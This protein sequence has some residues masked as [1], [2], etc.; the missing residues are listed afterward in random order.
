MQRE[1][2][3]N[4]VIPKPMPEDV[5]LSLTR[6]F[7]DPRETVD[8]YWFTDTIREYFERILELVAQ[9]RGQ[10]FWIEAEY[11]AGKTHF[12]ATL[13][14]LLAHTDDDTLWDLAKDDAV[15]TYRR[16]LASQRLFPVVLSLKGQSGVDEWSGRT[17]L[18][19]LEREGFGEALK[20]VG[21]HGQIQV[22]STD[23]LLAWFE[24]REAG[25]RAAIEWY[26]QA[27][28]DFTPQGY[29]AGHGRRALADVIRRYCDANDIQP[30][31]SASVKER[32]VH[33]FN[34]LTSPGLASRGVE[35][36][37]A[38]LVVID[39][40]EF[41]D[42]LHPSGTPEAAHDEEVLETLSFIMAKDLGLP[43][44]TLVGSQ[45][46]VPAKLRGGQEG[47]RFINT[48]LLKGA[49]EREY[50][51]IV[52]HRI[53]EL[54]P[55]RTPEINQY[56]DYYVSQFEFAKE[57]DRHTFFNIFPF[58]PHCFE[59]VRKVTAR[60]LPTARSGIYI[61]NQTLN[62][63]EAL[64]RDTLLIVSDLLNSQHLQEALS[65]TV[66]KE[67][68]QAYR[69]ALEALPSL[70]LDD[71]DGPLAEKILKTLFLWYLAYLE[72]PQLMSL[73]DLVEATLTSSDFLRNEDLV[74]LVLDR[75][76]VLPQIDFKDSSAS[77][78][79]A[80]VGVEPFFVKFDRFKRQITDRHEMQRAWQES[81]FFSPMETGGEQSLFGQFERDTLK[82]F[83]ISHHRIEY[84]GELVVATRWRAEYGQ[85][86]QAKDK[87]FRVVILTQIE[88]V[89]PLDLQDPR[90]AV[91][92]PG[93]LTPDVYEAA[94]DHLAAQAMA[95]DYRNRVGKEAEEVRQELRMH[96]R[97]QVIRNLLATHQRIYRAGRVVT[98]HDL[99]IKAADVFS[100]PSNDRR[101]EYVVDKLLISAYPN[102]PVQYG[103]LRKD[104][105]ARDT[106]KVFDGFFSPNP[107]RAEESAL[108]NFAIGLGLA[109]T[110]NPKRFAPDGAAVLKL[111][112]EML[113]EAGGG[114]LATWR[115]YEKLSSP[116]Y[117][118]PYT[119]ISLYLLCFV[120]HSQDPVVN[121]HL[122]PGHK[123]RLRSGDPPPH[124]VLRRGN[125]VQLTWTSGME[126]WFDLLAPT[127]DV[128]P[129]VVSFGRV[130]R[131]D[132]V[133]G[134]D[135]SA[136]EQQQA[137]LSETLADLRDRT[138]QT[139]RQLDLLRTAFDRSLV[140]DDQAALSRVAAVSQ[141]DTY[142][143]FY[144]RLGETYTQPEALQEDMATFRRLS[145]LAAA[146]AEIQTVRGY[147]NQIEP[148][149]LPPELAGERIVIQGQLNLETLA[150]QPHIWPS[151]RAQFERFR[152][153][154][155]NVYQ[156]HHRDT[157]KA[158]KQIQDD[159]ADVPH[160]LK[161][162]QLLNGVEA[163]G[164]SLGRG[165]PARYASLQD[166]L[167]T[168]DMGVSD[169]KVEMTPVCDV[170]RLPLSRQAP[171]EET[172][173]LRRDLGDAL[174]E[175]LRRL[176]TEAI[177]KVLAESGADRMEQL[178]KAIEL[179]SLD[180]LVDVL[181]EELMAFIAKALE[182]QGVGTVPTNVLQRL[183]DKYPILEEKDVPAFIDNLKALLEEAFAAAREEY[184]DKRT[185]R[186]SLK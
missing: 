7:D 49:G 162:L 167:R 186:I 134:E 67:A 131:D 31:T 105:S 66:Y 171:V 130:L 16:R 83:K 153:R 165:L 126:R 174:G 107:S 157:Y 163:L 128:W 179:S 149:A 2:L 18:S 26:I 99:G 111:I 11:G 159:L 3:H 20:R 4:L 103:Q 168:C 80:G 115:I 96:K 54:D 166:D 72:V 27:E 22:T 29:Q 121:L 21:L 94:K 129:Q 112:G 170:C 139:A 71:E 70:D 77:F 39:E 117:G 120:R 144:D 160:R 140:A 78:V 43:V 12:L 100:Q 118:L 5:T 15:R 41:W 169:L 114:E 58:Q 151:I 185:I 152:Q 176:K 13:A 102:L 178:V 25:L 101:L 110:E 122:K 143:S 35:P 113:D 61:L 82:S 64:S 52:S 95:D 68:A 136:V 173:R 30:R 45:T 57:L 104:F 161:A 75:M 87:H 19:V 116:P 109:R 147:L 183:A 84:P 55:E 127:E 37:T 73:T 177:R 146:T 125:V 40:W 133:I 10:G 148:D 182:I 97:L 184:P 38:L 145:E 34:Q 98:E 46:A 59:V 81:L 141:A 154:Y 74:A 108:G 93:P 56:Y 48:P 92:V 123:L 1:K 90:I 8:T 86:L 47:D 172:R 14:C 155:R 158:I 9:G 23:E 132:L 62:N 156:I 119:L 36:Y 33:I 63:D 106:G 42:R 65:T 79:V 142:Q 164:H 137:K 175:Q 60:E 6:S 85:R 17:L 50:D 44:L 28:T 53:R 91:L 76:S 89:A 138:Q 24:E 32:L 88:K 135:A 51:V 150:A 69:A 124:N 181:D 180:S